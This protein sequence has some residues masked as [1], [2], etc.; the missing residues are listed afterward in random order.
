MQQ[1]GEHRPAGGDE[2]DPL[3]VRLTL[4]DGDLVAEGKGFGILGPVARR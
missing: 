1:R 3:S 2:P 4:Q